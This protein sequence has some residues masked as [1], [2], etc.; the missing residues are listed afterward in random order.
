MLWPDFLHKIKLH[1]I[2]LTEEMVLERLLD[3]F[4][5]PKKYPWGQSSIEIIDEEGEKQQNFFDES[6]YIIPQKAIK[7]YEDGYTLILSNCGGFVKDT[8]IIQQWLNDYCNSFRNCNLYFGNGKKTVSFKKHNHNH[9]VLVKNIYGESDWI[10]DG[11]EYTL[12]EQNAVA[13]K[14]YI[15]HEVVGLKSPKL[16]MTCNL[17][18]LID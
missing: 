15:D 6:G 16:S 1:K 10:I 2:H 9:G 11:R 13:F 17:G 14:S 12:K 18:N 5:W 8:W 4:R 3:K 7:A